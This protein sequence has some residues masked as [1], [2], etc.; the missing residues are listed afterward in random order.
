M[1]KR[2]FCLNYKK[3]QSGFTLLELLLVVAGI[4]I[5][6]TLIF[7]VL[8]PGETLG[9]FRDAKRESDLHALMSAMEMY[10]FDNNG[11]VPDSAS[12]GW[13]VDDTPVAI[14]TGTSA[15]LPTENGGTGD[16]ATTCDLGFVDLLTG[17]EYL[18]KIPTDPGTGSTSVSDGDTG[19]TA[20]IDS[21]G[22]VTLTATDS[23]GDPI[24]VI[25]KF[26]HP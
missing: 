9:Q 26:T 18:T 16:D 12:T 6:A 1:N 4:A 15:D 3:K 11:N 10:A 24:T 25:G 14:C 20:E 17:A 8:K 21:T 19:Y 13:D 2:I 5:L 22:L 23:S 7:V